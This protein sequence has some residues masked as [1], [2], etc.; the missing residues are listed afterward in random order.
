MEGDGMRSEAALE[1]RVRASR[2]GD[3]GVVD[4]LVAFL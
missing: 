1:S 3:G 4:A 2:E